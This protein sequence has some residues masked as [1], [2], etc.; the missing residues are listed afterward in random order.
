MTTLGRRNLKVDN[1]GK[2]KSEKGQLCKRIK[3]EKGQ[4]WKGQ[5]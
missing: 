4:F 3:S 1:S 5:I 2:E